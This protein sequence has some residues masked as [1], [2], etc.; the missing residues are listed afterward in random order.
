MSDAVNHPSHYNQG[1]IEVIDYIEDRQFN[2]NV[3]NAVKY[4]CRAQYKGKTVEDLE[5][6][7]F[8]LKRELKRKPYRKNTIYNYSAS[9]F[10]DHLPLSLQLAIVSI[11]SAVLEY[12]VE[13]YEKAIVILE[14]YIAIL[15][16]I[17]SREYTKLCTNSVK[18]R[19]S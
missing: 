13:K 3:G 6:A 7:V 18:L 19:N 15:K 5:K 10:V 12:T 4:I 9:D 2:F 1:A 8:Y 16:D 11:D 17:N 14:K